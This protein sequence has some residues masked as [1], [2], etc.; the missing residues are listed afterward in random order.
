MIINTCRKFQYFAI[1][2]GTKRLS[3]IPLVVLC[4]LFLFPVVSK[5]AACSQ[6]HS[7]IVNC[8][9]N[10]P[11]HHGIANGW[12][13]NSAWADVAVSYA[14]DSGADGTAQKIDCSSY[15]S[16]AVQF[17]YPEIQLQKDHVYQIDI[18]MKGDVRS[19]VEILLRQYGKPYE[20]YAAKA[21]MVDNDW[22]KY[23]Y[24]GVVH[25]NASRAY[26]MI[27]FTGTGTVWLDDASMKDITSVTVDNSQINGNLI[28]N[29]SFEVGLDRWG[30]LV[31]E[32]AYEKAMLIESLDRRPQIDS[33]YAHHGQHSF[34][35]NVPDNARVVITSPYLTIIPGRTYHLSCWIAAETERS[36]SI[37][38]GHGTLQ[39]G[40]IERQ[41]VQIGHSWKR[42]RRTIQLKPAPENAYYFIFESNGAGTLWLDEICLSDV[43][44]SDYQP[45]RPIEIGFKR[46]GQPT[47]FDGTEEIKASVLISALP[48]EDQARLKIRSIDYFNNRQIL[49]DEVLNFSDDYTQQFTITHPNDSTGYFRL[50]AELSQDHEIID[51][52]EMA[53]GI[54]PER[55]HGP[56]LS[57]P[58]GNH[59]RFNTDQF[60]IARKL[61]I[62]WLRMHPP[63]G[64][65]WYIVEKEKGTF[66]FYDESIL[67]AKSYGFHILGLLDT[68]P[69]WSSSAPV[70][71]VSPDMKGFR[72]YPAKDLADWEN[73]VFQ[74]VQYYRGIIDY[75][76]VWNE[77]ETHFF[78]INSRFDRRTKPETYVRLLKVAYKAAKKANPN[79]VIIGGGTV[80]KPLHRW[81][82]EIIS[83]GAYDY[84]DILSFHGYT[85]DRPGDDLDISTSFY[86]NE[87]ESLMRQYNPEYTKAIWDT[88]SGIC[89][90]ET[91]YQ[92][93][94]EVSDEYACPGQSGPHYL[95]RNFIHLQA[96]GTA[97]WFYYSMITSH[98]SDRRECTGFFEWDG[99]PRPLAVAYAVLSSFLEDAHFERMLELPYGFSGARF[100]AQDKVISIVYKQ[101]GDEKKIIALPVTGGESVKA[102]NV[103]GNPVKIEVG[104]SN[105]VSLLIGKDPLYVIE[106]VPMVVVPPG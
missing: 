83:S 101:G 37:G 20:K 44:S 5:K 27:R 3:L 65:K 14:Q 43:D 80:Q 47:I 105:T 34:K 90:P 63:H 26:F 100:K 31:R 95:I 38:L 48:T 89:N 35:V 10:G 82:K 60:V 6:E 28:P 51:K 59:V 86:L 1:L 12:R 73:Y 88:E 69:R 25:E 67:S 53:I 9:F 19:P 96:N 52:A 8:D 79:A 106:S 30:V 33:Q 87:F 76:E 21:F 68:T 22:Q 42:Y 84:F 7:T 72:S 103:M 16:G 71:E 92:N 62:S 56:E 36:V 40:E 91:N 2:L 15:R 24:I 50:E 49:L 85:N 4:V 98:R 46:E 23:S 64:T 78:N 32:K 55:I 11:Y 29:S 61:G 41:H 93:I 81:I 70:S 54:V 45:R 74:T 13:D 18:W 75:W 97:K 94:F 39:N 77:P 66:N 99:S 102:Y 57:S 17:V 104:Q 58:F